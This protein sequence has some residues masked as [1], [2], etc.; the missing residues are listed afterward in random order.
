MTI[1]HQGQSG[2]LCFPCNDTLSKVSIS[3]ATSPPEC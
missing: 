3:I 1:N 2:G